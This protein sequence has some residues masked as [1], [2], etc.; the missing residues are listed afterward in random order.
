MRYNRDI[1]TELRDMLNAD[2][3]SASAH[4]IPA[5]L[6]TS[7]PHVHVVRTG[8]YESDLVLENNYMDFDVYAEDVA[9]AMTAAAS[10]CGW[11]RDL[12]G[13]YSYVANI[14]T[15]PYHNPDP[16]HPD[17]ARATFKAQILTR[18]V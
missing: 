7:L 2:G 17:I 8:G 9:E 18:T 4:T 3:Y 16:R 15:L 14:T 1:E 5:T 11:V 10:L 12:E 6:G 13:D